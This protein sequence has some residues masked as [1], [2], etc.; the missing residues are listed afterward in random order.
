MCIIVVKPLTTFRCQFAGGDGE[1]SMYRGLSTLFKVVR[2]EK[3]ELAVWH[4]EAKLV[5]D[6]RDT[7]L[8]GTVDECWDYVESKEG[9]EGYL[10]RFMIER[11]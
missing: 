1:S 8:F 7:G 6:W 11:W 2:S 3:E 5:S 10:F 9:S 4:A